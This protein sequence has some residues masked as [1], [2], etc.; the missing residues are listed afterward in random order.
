MFATEAGR[1]RRRVACAVVAAGITTVGL[2]LASASQAASAGPDLA[3]TSSRDGN[4][5]IYVMNADGGGVARLTDHPAKDFHPAW[6]P[7]GRRVAFASDRDGD[8]EIYVMR[9]DGSDL[10]QLTST[11]ETGVDQRPAWSPDGRE[12]LFDRPAVPE[13]GFHLDLY[14]V[15]IATGALRRL[16][17]GGG[18]SS[19]G[20]DGDWSPRQTIVLQRHTDTSDWEIGHLDPATGAVTQLTSNS[21]DDITPAW[22]P[23]GSQ[24]VFTSRRSGTFD[25]WKMASN[26]TG[27]VRLTM[28]GGSE[29]GPDVS[30]D[31]SRIAYVSDQDGNSEIYAMLADGS[32]PT[33]LTNDAAVDTHPSWRCLRNTPPA[34]VDDAAETSEDAVLD[35]APPGV[36]ANDADPEG[37]SFTIELAE[38]PVH[39][40]VTLRPDGSFTY[41]SDPDF[42]GNDLF[43]Y[44]ATDVHGATATATVFITVKP[45]NDDPVANPDATSTSQYTPVTIDVLAND[46]DADGDALSIAAVSAPSHGEAS[47]EDGKITYAPAPTFKESDSFSYTVADGQGGTDEGTV[48]VTAIGC[49]ED[50]H[51][52]LRGT[53]LDG[54]LSG[55]IDREIEPV[56]GSVDAGPARAVHEANCEII[57]PAEDA[58]GSP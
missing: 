27:A 51:E 30:C 47:I 28:Q 2:A 19:G 34:L 26:G 49:G 53:L 58:T 32:S 33:R 6:S 17:N 35:V 16:T 56:V 55:T 48:T 57:V 20:G 12:V 8:F 39:G 18:I 14:A 45:A 15:D 41:M 42:H 54:L 13:T 4:P 44:R 36:L 10:R 22:F 11:D 29:A 5:E 1:T 3:F 38:P 52:A 21:S 46:T 9:A 37:D 50:G 25:I 31:G 43:R 40:D 24:I 23:D 7:D